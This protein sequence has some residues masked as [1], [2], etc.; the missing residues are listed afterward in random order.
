MDAT[1]GFTYSYLASL[2]IS[3]QQS[4]PILNLTI[5][6]EQLF[7]LPVY[8]CLLQRPPSFT[9]VS[10]RQRII[11][12]S[13]N[14][15]LTTIFTVITTIFTARSSYLRRDHHHLNF[16]GRFRRNQG[17]SVEL[18]HISVPARSATSAG[19]ESTKKNPKR[20]FPPSSSSETTRHR[21]LTPRR[22]SSVVH[23]GRR[24]P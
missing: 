6:A 24:R 7:T 8:S 14:R 17:L 18:C 21:R 12:I 11:R 19:R 23:R 9:S 1:L 13:S 22:A 15:G 10:P 20:F 16:Q 4:D 3:G 2:K 5:L